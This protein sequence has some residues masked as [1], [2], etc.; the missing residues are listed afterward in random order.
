MSLNNRFF[1]T[2]R[3]TISRNPDLIKQG[4]FESI[5]KLGYGIKALINYLKSSDYK[6]TK[7]KKP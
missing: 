7:F 3:M 6:G 5:E 1:T 4:K 2:F